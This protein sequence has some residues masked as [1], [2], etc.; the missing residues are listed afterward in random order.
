M[1][2]NCPECQ[3]DQSHMLWAGGGKSLEAYPTHGKASPASSRQLSL[4]RPQGRMACGRQLQVC[5]LGN[6]PGPQERAWSAG[7]RELFLPP[8]ARVILLS[9]LPYSARRLTNHSHFLSM[10]PVSCEVAFLAMVGMEW[11]GNVCRGR[12]AA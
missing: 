5:V 9:P 2:Q 3:C 6:E 8:N 10:D 7:S 1:F 4:T 11:T 12:Q